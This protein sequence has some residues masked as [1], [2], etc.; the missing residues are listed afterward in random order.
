MNAEQTGPELTKA[1]QKKAFRKLVRSLAKAKGVSPEQAKRDLLETLPVE[2]AAQFAEIEE[3]T[4]MRGRRPKTTKQPTRPERIERLRAA[5][6]GLHQG[7]LDDGF[8][9]YMKPAGAIQTVA[10]ALEDPRTGGRIA[11]VEEP[12]GTYIQRVGIADNYQQRPPFDH[13]TDS[14]YRRLIRDFIEGAIMPEAK[15]AALGPITSDRRVEEL[16]Q[17]GLEFSVIDGLQRLYCYCI[18][19]LLVWRR[20]ALVRDGIIPKDAW[21]YFREQVEALGDAKTATAALLER[22]VRY[23][24]F[25]RIGLDGLLHYMVTFNTGQRRM[26][27]PM[28]LEIMQKPLIDELEQKARIKVWHE[29]NKLPGMARPKDQFAAMELVLATKAFITNNAQVAASEEAETFLEDPAFL[30]NVG[31]ISDVVDTLTRVTTEIHPL[32]M[33]LYAD[34]PSRRFILSGG[35]TFFISFMAACGYTRNRGNQKMLDGALDKLVAKL[36]KPASDDPLN[37]EEYQAALASI[38][39]SRGKSIRRLVYDTFLRF[40]N[41]VTSELEWRDTASQITGFAEN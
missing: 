37:L 9:S 34:D 14:I 8:G 24:I 1:E 35:G 36:K 17:P 27:L 10:T 29:R 33:Q 40:F 39:S 4:T 41:G 32:I 2:M 23:E 11:H 12:L 5:I 7:L 22:T 26:S 38:T 31:D 25:Y 16:S 15:V 3:D 19:I 13:V 20:E 30:E 6:T 21:E 18:A 28:Q